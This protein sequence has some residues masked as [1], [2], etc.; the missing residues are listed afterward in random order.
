MK[1][2]IG[3]I[4]IVC[5]ISLE[6]IY[7]YNR[8]FS[9]SG[10]WWL[11]IVQG[12]ALTIL[13]MGLFLIRQDKRVWLLIVPLMLYSI[14]NTSA[15]QRESL[16]LKVKG[17]K[18]EIN[19][20]K[21]EDMESAIKRK[22]DRSTKITE[23][24]DASI[25]SFDDAYEW[26][27]TTAKYESEQKTLDIE[28]ETLRSELADLR[29][30]PAELNSNF[31]LYQF[32]SK[33]LHVSADALQLILQVIFSFFISIMAPVGVLL[34]PNN[35]PKPDPEPVEEINWKDLVSKWVH[36]NW[37][38]VRTGKGQELF[39]RANFEEWTIN[40]GAEFPEGAYDKI[41]KTAEK[42][43]VVDNNLIVCNDESEAISRIVKLV[44]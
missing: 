6:V 36:I 30:P 1:R 4:L 17:E 20:Q 12:V 37:I 35:R 5:G 23:L 16:L 41:K 26:K 32:Y 10:N 31:Q 43:K 3:F 25:S 39:S 11:S 9:E 44:R 40:R 28:L 34:I 42:A 29:D 22:E 8:F 7:Y 27:N 24:M 21:I 38:R 19:N 13:L 33:F 14:F 18:Q 2:G 15:G